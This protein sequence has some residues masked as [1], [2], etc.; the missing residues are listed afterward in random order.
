MSSLKEYLLVDSC[1]SQKLKKM[2]INLCTC[3]F[4]ILFAVYVKIVLLNELISV[5]I[6]VILTY[7]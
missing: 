3:V 4:F 7:K 6:K 1:Y 5:Y 2:K